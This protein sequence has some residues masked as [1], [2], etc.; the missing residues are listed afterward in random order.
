LVDG[1]TAAPG[2]KLRNRQRI[3]VLPAPDRVLPDEFPR[4]AALSDDLAALYKPAGWHSARLAGSADDGS[5]SVEGF[6]AASAPPLVTAGPTDSGFVPCLLNRLDQTTSGLIML[7]RT[8][9]GRERWLRSERSGHIDKQYIALVEGIPAAPLHIRQTLAANDR[10][11]VRALDR[12]NPDPLRHT[13][14]V[15][16]GVVAP[17]RAALLFPG[18]PDIPRL[19]LL[20]C[21]IR[22]GARHQIR[23][24]LAG[25]GHPLFGDTLYGG[26]QAPHLL[27]HHIRL[28]M[29]GFSAF[30]P[31]PWLDQLPGDLAALLT[32]EAVSRVHTD[33]SAP[34]DPQPKRIRA[35]SSAGIC[36]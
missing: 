17:E 12:D 11:R 7:A 10:V 4:L 2:C 31:P 34:D 25:A 33:G 28:D 22:L 36:P 26:R 24:H 14:A 3:V 5:G 21:C 1:R 29:P 19:S 16:L 13:L 9:S 20:L 6:L 35:A 32:P 23:A 15:P 27:L 8:A 18:I 30:C